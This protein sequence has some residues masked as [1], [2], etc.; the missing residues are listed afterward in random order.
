MLFISGLGKGH[1][2]QLL[3]L[4]RNDA[5]YYVQ[6]AQA[7]LIAELAID[8]PKAVFD[9]IRQNE[10]SYNIN[11]K[12][13]QKICDSYRISYAWKTRFKRLRAERRTHGTVSPKEGPGL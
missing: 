12:A 5:E 10:L 8:E 1:A 7:W 9:W 4:M 13:I 3:S 6:M 2:A 11:G